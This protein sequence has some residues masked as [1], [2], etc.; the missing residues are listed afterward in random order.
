MNYDNHIEI[1]LAKKRFE[2]YKSMNLKYPEL[3]DDT[4]RFIEVELEFQI[5]RS[6]EVVNLQTTEIKSKRPR[7]WFQ[8][9]KHIKTTDE[10]FVKCAKKVVTTY[11]NWKAYKM[12]NEFV[13]KL[14]LESI[15]FSYHTKYFDKAN[16]IE[17][18]P[19]IKP[20]Q[21]EKSD[22]YLRIIECKYGCD[23]IC[24]IL[25]TID[26]QGVLS[27]IEF[28]G[29]EGKIS[30]IQAVNELKSLGNWKPAIKDGK[31]VKTQL[32]LLIYI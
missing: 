12:K 18:N 5:S 19:D 7:T 31:N 22:K 25:C 26:E 30:G 2:Q 3:E 11:N 10:Q 20:Y 29:N 24:N 6:N 32:D 23:G 1:Q 27:D 8:N 4:N 16:N 14:I 13:D 9:E 17:L 15:H 28:L 21:Q